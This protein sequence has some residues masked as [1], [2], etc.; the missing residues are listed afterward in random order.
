[1][2]H[3][4]PR[5]PKKSARLIPPLPVV[6]MHAIPLKYRPYIAAL[7]FLLAAGLSACDDTSGGCETVECGA[8]EVCVESSQ[9]CECTDAYERRDGVCVPIGCTHDDDCSDGLACNGVE[10]CDGE[11]RTCMPGIAVLCGDGM[12]CS[13]P[14]GECSCGGGFL[15]MGDGCECPAGYRITDGTCAVIR[16]C[17]TDADCDDGVFCNGEEVCQSNGTCLLSGP[18]FV[19]VH[20]CAAPNEVCDEASQECT[21]RSGYFDD[22]A[23]CQLD[24]CMGL[25]DEDCAISGDL[26]PVPVGPAMRFIQSDAVLNFVSEPGFLVEL[27]FETSGETPISTD[28]SSYASLDLSTVDAESIRVFARATDG[29]CTPGDVFDFTYILVDAYAPTPDVAGDAPRFPQFPAYLPDEHNLVLATGEPNP[30]FKGWATAW[31]D[32]RY[33]GSVEYTWRKPQNALGIAGGTFA[34]VSLGNRGEITLQFDPP[35]ANEDGADFAV[36]ENGFIVT[37]QPGQLPADIAFIEVSSDGEN[38][39]RFDTHTLQAQNPGAY[40]P[41]SPTRYNNLAGT[42]PALWGT[43]FDLGELVNRE[44]VRRGVVDLQRITHVR[45]IDI[46]GDGTTYDSFGNPL[47]DANPSW[48]SG[49]FDLD[50]IGVIHQ[51]TP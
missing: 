39:I 40:G 1:M 18:S 26:C 46:V 29:D 9:T 48:G 21:C 32:V 27:R 25:S 49:G 13:K 50:A 24:P 19:G 20:D 44:A 47:Y 7:A 5:T 35:I 14:A 23:Q 42:Q 3:Q 51:A 10:T 6:T 12:T 2:P 43:P 4:R 41:I 28:W 34:I 30:I 45:V 15:D 33:G 38:F 17:E 22:G 36:F 11:T 31:D 8:A 37:G 16:D